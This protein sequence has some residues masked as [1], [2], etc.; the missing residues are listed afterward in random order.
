MMFSWMTTKKRRKG[1]IIINITIK[2]KIN[3]TVVKCLN[4]HKIINLHGVDAKST[5]EILINI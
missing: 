1:N 5:Q 4:Q 3:Y 2:L